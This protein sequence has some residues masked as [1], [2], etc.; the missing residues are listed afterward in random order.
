WGQD[1]PLATTAGH[2]IDYIAL[3]GTLHSI[4]EAK[5]PVP[6]LNL[7]GDFGGGG[8]M[9][10]MGV[11]AGVFAV[12]AGAT[13]QVVDAAMVDGS[14]LLASM[15]FS[16]MAAGRWESRRETNLLDGGAPFYTTYQTSDGHHMAVGALEPQFFEA[17]LDGLSI[18]RSEIPPQGDRVGWPLMRE[19]F[20]ARFAEATREQWTTRFEGSDACVTPILS[21]SEAPKHPHNIERSTF[22]PFGEAVQPHPAPRFSATP[23]DLPQLPPAPGANTDSVMTGLGYSPDQV[24]MLRRAGAIA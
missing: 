14:A 16:E 15:Q 24:V 3:S 11:L 2:D 8:M 7:V 19:V 22:L 10:A 17:L 12:S 18:E 23:T 5:R 20:A 13:R 1:G 6:P 4:G 21:L 9:L